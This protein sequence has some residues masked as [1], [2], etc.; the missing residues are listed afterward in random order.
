MFARLIAACAVAVASGSAMAVTVVKQTISFDT[1]APFGT[2]TQGQFVKSGWTDGVNPVA[3]PFSNPNQITNILVE[4]KSTDANYQTQTGTTAAGQPANTHPFG[5]LPCVGFNVLNPNRVG[6]VSFT[7]SN[8]H[9]NLFEYGDPQDRFG[10][11]VDLLTDAANS[12]A[13]P[14]N[15]G[16]K[17]GGFVSYIDNTTNNPVSSG[18]FT[19]ASSSTLTLTLTGTGGITPEPTSLALVG[20]ALTLV[21]RKR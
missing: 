13:N 14:G 4:F 1:I 21:R 7:K 3:F 6:V 5:G 9:A 19:F 8:D 12:G 10:I 11:T 18:D 17:L 15:L 20:G 2:Y 16:V